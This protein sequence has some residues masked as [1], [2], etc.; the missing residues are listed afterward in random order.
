MESLKDESLA[1][2]V[3]LVICVED[4]KEDDNCRMIPHQI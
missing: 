1:K 2:R 4:P 3:V